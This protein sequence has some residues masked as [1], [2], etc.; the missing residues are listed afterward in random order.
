MTIKSRTIIGISR[1]WHRPQSPT[2][3]DNRAEPL[4][5]LKSS[6]QDQIFMEIP[7]I[8]FKTGYSAESADSDAIP[9]AIVDSFRAVRGSI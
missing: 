8:T 7:K 4:R 5:K 3:S 9:T 2:A 6:L 1:F